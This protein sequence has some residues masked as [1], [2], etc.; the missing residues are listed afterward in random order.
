MTHPSLNSDGRLSRRAV[1]RN[2]GFAVLGVP[3]FDWLLAHELH[4]AAKSAA[5]APE[6]LAPLNRFPRMVHE[7]F[8]ARVRQIEQENNNRRAALRTRSDALAYIRS[9]REKIQESFGPWPEKTPLNPRVTGVLERDAY[10]IEKILF[11]SRPG[12]LVTANLYVPKGRKFPLP[13]VVGVCGHSTNGKAADAYQSFSQ[14][15]ARMGYVTLIFD[16]IGQ[17]ERSQ[18]TDENLKPRI[19]LGVQQHLQAGNQQFL[20]GEFLGTWRAWDG[21]RALD[22]LLSR[23]EV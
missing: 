15:L 3:L 18:Y 13:G 20:V 2:V 23:P 16:P 22:Y 11:E 21:I 19:A 14:A 8:V 10:H 6:P 5:P 1:L 4:A 12:F 7:F 17:G 9:V